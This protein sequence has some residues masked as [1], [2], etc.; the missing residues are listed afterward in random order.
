MRDNAEKS[1][2]TATESVSNSKLINYSIRKVA[3]TTAVISFRIL[4]LS[5]TP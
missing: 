2:K 5:L 3:F 1:E 4:L